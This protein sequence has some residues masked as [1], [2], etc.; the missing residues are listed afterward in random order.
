MQ[1]KEK[2]SPHSTAESAAAP[3]T[4]EALRARIDA[5][6][7]ALIAL[8]RERMGVIAEVAVLKNHQHA[9]RCHIRSGREGQMHRRIAA[10]FRGSDFPPAAALAIWRQ[11][12]AAASH[13]E[14]PLMIAS[15][16]PAHLAREYFGS[17]PEHR[18]LPHAEGALGEVA[19]GNATIAVIPP[20][21]AAALTRFPQLKIFAALP[22][23]GKSI[24]ALAVAELMPEASGEDVSY[25]A[26][27]QGKVTTMAGFVT[28]CPDATWLGAH[29]QPLKW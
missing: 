21:G 5:L 22:L 4:L 29:P 23:V 14:A 15:A 13:R 12:I 18:A 3:P 10:A 11:L 1:S 24:E 25:F 17:F 6:D 28:E 19:R 27:A 9:A 7:D 8:I 26:N 2:P 20:S 16:A